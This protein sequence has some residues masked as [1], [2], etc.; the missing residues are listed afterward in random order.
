MPNLVPP[1]GVVGSQVRWS[2]RILR[3]ATPSIELQDYIPRLARACLHPD[4][5][6]M[7]P[8]FLCG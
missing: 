8:A 3:I 1:R 2:G 6:A 7:P 5:P 4:N